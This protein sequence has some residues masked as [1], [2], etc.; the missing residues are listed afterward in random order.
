MN[1]TATSTDRPGT[2]ARHLLR[3][4][5]QA[6][7]L[8]LNRHPLL[9]GLVQPGYPLESY[10]LL[11]A[12]WFHFHRA[13]EASIEAFVADTP[14]FDYAMRRKLPWLVADLRALDVAPDTPR[15][16]P[17]RPPRRIE[18]DSVAQLAGVLYTLEGSTLGG[19]VIARHI[20]VTLG[21]NA[22][23]GARFFNGYEDRTEERWNQFVTFLE[24]ACADATTRQQ[25]GIAATATFAAL[26][27]LLDDY[28]TKRHG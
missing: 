9:A 18:I 22:Q 15:F 13:L 3:Q 12:A 17:S 2:G 11:L 16:S 4:R 6:A 27:E 1:C 14:V 25:A 23:R 28:R 20:A 21:L 5:T 19:Q 8:A 26:R 24:T 7:H 10:R